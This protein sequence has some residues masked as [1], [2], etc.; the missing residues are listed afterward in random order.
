LKIKANSLSQKKTHQVKGQTS[1]IA[2]SATNI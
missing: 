2:S 1:G